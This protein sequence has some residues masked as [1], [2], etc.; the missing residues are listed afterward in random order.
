MERIITIKGSLENICKAESI[1]SGKLRQCYESDLAAIAPQALMFPGLHPMAMMS[2]L[3]TPGYSA[4]PPRSGPSTAGPY[5]IYN[6][7]NYSIPPVMGYPP[8]SSGPPVNTSS[9]ALTAG[10]QAVQGDPTKE[11]VNLYIPNSAV[12]AIIGTGGS[13]IRDMISSSGASIKVRILY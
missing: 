12:G 10:F 8:G 9:S 2:T 11:T 1:I 13:T 4:P 7:P 5:G 6:A 3:N